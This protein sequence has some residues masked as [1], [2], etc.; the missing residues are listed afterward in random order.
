[1][2]KIFLTLLV[3]GSLLTACNSGSSNS[4][5]SDAS[6]SENTEAAVNQEAKSEHAMLGVQ[7]LCEMCKATI[8]KAAM[9]VDGVES[10]E[11][12]MDKKEL[13]FNF[14]SSKTSLDAI[15][16]AIA[17]VGYDTEKDKADDSVYNALPD[18]CKYRK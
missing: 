11:W 2:K 8:E 12:D 9:G 3:G 1:M 16:K 7:G 4:Q 18:C 15:S 5:T 6:K 10:A 13:H 17:K 14:N